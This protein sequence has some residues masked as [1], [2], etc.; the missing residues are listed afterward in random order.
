VRIAVFGLGYVGCVSAACFARRGHTVVGVDVNTDKVGMMSEG[1]SP[2]LEPGLPELVAEQVATGRLTA[3]MD[4][5]RALAE[6]ELSV[7]CV[8]TPS[9]RSGA[10][11]LD[12]LERVAESIGQ[13]LPR[14]GPRHTVVIRSTVLPGTTENIVLP[15][16]SRGS[17]REPGA[18]LGVA[19]NPEF[20]REGSAIADFD[21]PPKTVIGELDGESGDAVAALYDGIDAPLFRVPLRIA[22][23]AKFAD[24]AF[25]ALKIAFANEIGVLARESGIDSYELMSLFVADRKLNISD[26]YLRP[27]FAFG[28]S[29][30]PKDLRALI[31]TARRADLDLPLLESI[32][33]ANE[34]HLERTLDV[35]LAL[36]RRRVG[37]LGLAF[38]PGVDD[39]RESPLVE[40]AERLIGKGYELKIYDRAVSVSRL[41]GANRE[42]ML[43]HLP[44]LSELLVESPTEVLEHAEVCIV[45]SASPEAVEALAASDARH[46]VDLVRLPD[47]SRRRGEDLYVG[48]AW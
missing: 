13:H 44:H 25:H 18:T 6:A 7:I 40:L 31:H 5:G 10:Q 36:G 9:T 16:V 1:R 23:L 2:V 21:A 39:L 37:M 4:A 47:A 38:K 29:C 41:V 45:G 19:V 22:E 12:A 33:P 8:G 24:N 11:D 48:V 30:L 27:G 26:A 20:L 14:A 34:R 43:E 15:R 32:L 17:R 35:V 28:G 3:T 46:V 42:Y